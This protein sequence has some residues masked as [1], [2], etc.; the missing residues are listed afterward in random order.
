MRDGC[1]DPPSLSAPP[2]RRPPPNPP[3]PGP[4]LRSHRQPTSP[5]P[6][7]DPIRH[8]LEIATPP[9]PPP[10]ATWPPKS[11]AS[12][13]SFTSSGFF[14][15]PPSHVSMSPRRSTA[16]SGQQPRGDP[17]PRMGRMSGHQWGIP[18]AAD[19]EKRMAAAKSS[20]LALTGASF[21]MGPSA[22]PPSPCGGATGACRAC[23]VLVCSGDRFPS[24][25][26]PLAVDP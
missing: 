13:I 8:R 11:Y 23:R 14:N 1:P 17:W 18:M 15:P 10:R 4:S 6:S 25:A 21:I 26:S 2:A 22:Q 16:S 20:G 7:S 19:G 12:K 5:L 3:A 9:T 24:P